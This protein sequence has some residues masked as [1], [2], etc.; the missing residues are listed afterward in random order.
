MQHIRTRIREVVHLGNSAVPVM[1]FPPSPP[2]PSP[3]HAGSARP[4]HEFRTTSGETAHLGSTAHLPPSPPCSAHFLP[5]LSFVLLG[6]Y[7]STSAAH[8]P[9]VCASLY[10]T[11]RCSFHPQSSRPATSSKRTLTPTSK[12]I[13]LIVPLYSPAYPR[14]YASSVA[15][16]TE[17]P[18]ASL[19]NT[20]GHSASGSTS[21]S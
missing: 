10:S 6:I 3:A 17:G 21:R 18:R 9:G 12:I 16:T 2:S 14:L 20:R 5:I 19:P 11:A 4:P 8:E 13:A 1:S 15:C 7:P